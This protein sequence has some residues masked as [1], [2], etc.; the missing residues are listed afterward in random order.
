MNA[1][2]FRNADRKLIER[3]LNRILDDTV[4]GFDGRYNVVEC[5]EKRKTW[6]GLLH[7]IHYKPKNAFGRSFCN[8]IRDPGVKNYSA[9]SVFES[10]MRDGYPVM[11]AKTLVHYKGTGALMRNLNYILSRCENEHDIGEVLACLK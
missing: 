10:Y 3:V 11:A 1:L 6:C 9:W 4:P 7:H 5:M 8:D 2:R